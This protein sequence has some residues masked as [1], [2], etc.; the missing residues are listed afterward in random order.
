MSKTNEIIHNNTE[1]LIS[2][3]NDLINLLNLQK[4]DEL[5]NTITCFK[6]IKDEYQ[7]INL[8]YLNELTDSL[9]SLNISNDSNSQYHCMMLSSNITSRLD[10]YS[11]KIVSFI[12]SEIE[13]KHSQIQ[14]VKNLLTQIER[15]DLNIKVKKYDCDLCESCKEV[16]E[17][18][19][20]NESQSK[21]NSCGLVK[22]HEYDYD[23]F[24]DLKSPNTDTVKKSKRGTHE[25]EKH[26]IIWLDKITAIKETNITEEQDAKIRKWFSINNIRN[27]KL[28]TCENY[29]RCFKESRITELND[30]VTYIRLIYSGISPPRI[31]YDERQEIISWFV[32]IVEIYEDIKTED[33][34]IKY[35]PFFI[36]KIV[37]NIIKDKQR[38]TDIQTCIHLQ[39][40]ETLKSNDNIYKAIINTGRLPFSFNKTD[41]N[42]TY[43]I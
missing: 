9:S 3:I 8:L 30:F 37:P 35:Y 36:Y 22:S 31:S 43:K 39:S 40:P 34:N 21:C 41:S 33:N 38:A 20:I 14:Q 29:R 25:A 18:K 24:D 42:P 5:S 13:L 27:P 12:K 1:L 11:K 15:I 32:H 4:Y 10:I 28:L 17:S 19:P 23:D 2:H 26:C 16:T 6:K 7:L